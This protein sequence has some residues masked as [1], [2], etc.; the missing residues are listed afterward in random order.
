M[1]ISNSITIHGMRPKMFKTHTHTQ[2]H[3]SSQKMQSVGEKARERERVRGKRERE[4]ERER[5]RTSVYYRIVT[6]K[7]R[8]GP[9]GEGSKR[10]GG[11]GEGRNGD[12]TKW[13]G[14]SCEGGLLKEMHSGVGERGGGR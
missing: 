13:G 8:G 5:V 4:R 6:V 10:I 2:I 9:R 12:S 3:R 1:T 14:G 11:R 7:A